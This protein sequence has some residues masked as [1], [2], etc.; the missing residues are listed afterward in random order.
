MK[1]TS[2]FLILAIF[3]VFGCISI[4][5]NSAKSIEVKELKCEYFKNPIGLGDTE[6]R[7]SW[8]MTSDEQGQYQSAYQVLVAN[9]P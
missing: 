8:I 6:P 3:A 9:F 7:L 5:A 4:A 1:R 2:T